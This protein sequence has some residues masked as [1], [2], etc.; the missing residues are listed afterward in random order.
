MTNQIHRLQQNEITDAD[1]AKALEATKN[2]LVKIDIIKV[3][4]LRR[5]FDLPPEALGYVVDVYT[6]LLTGGSNRNVMPIHSDGPVKRNETTIIKGRVMHAAFT[7][8][9]VF[10]S[11]AGTTCGAADWIINDIL[12]DG[13]SQFEQAG[14]LPGDMFQSQAIDSFVSFTMC[15]KELVVVA[16]YI[17]ENENGCSFYGSII[18]TCDLNQHTEK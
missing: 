18:G 16:T 7:P 4:Q 1:R 14:P 3:D 17:G 15:R 10:V 2:Y 5:Q 12:V 9:R 11:M 6:A 8:E 13:K